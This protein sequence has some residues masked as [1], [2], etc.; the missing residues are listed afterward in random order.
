[1]IRDALVSISLFLVFTATVGV[2]LLTCAPA[3]PDLSKARAE[4]LVLAPASH[5]V[6][7]EDEHGGGGAGWNVHGPQPTL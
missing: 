3:R 6:V 7:M 5:W 1:M 4:G 2:Y